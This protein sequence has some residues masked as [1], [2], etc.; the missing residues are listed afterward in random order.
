[1]SLLT[2]DDLTIAF[3][4][5]IAVNSVTTRIEKGQ[6][7][8]LIGPNGSGKTT[9]F[10]LISGIYKPTRGQIMLDGVDISYLRPDKV[11]EMGISRTFQNIRLFKDLTVLENVLIGSHCRINTRF[12]DDLFDSKRKREE[13]KK[14]VAN[15]VELLDMFDLLD[16]KDEKAKN[17]PYGKQREL[18]IVRAIASQPKLILLDEPAAGMNPQESQNLMKLIFKVRDRGLTVLIVEHDMKVVMGICD[19]IAVLNYGKKIA[20]D[21]PENIQ[22][23]EEVILAYLGRRDAQNA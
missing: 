4:G 23:N 2:L 8:G 17:L 5:L 18:E 10:N 15:A 1:M 19:R 7:F 16:L 6:I 22:K 21:T 13:E 9:I 20:E 11:A 12:L 3:G 14:A